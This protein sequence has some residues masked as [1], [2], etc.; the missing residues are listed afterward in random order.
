MRYVTLAR[1]GRTALNTEGRL[2]GLA[3]PPLDDEGR[4]EAA[5]LAGDLAGWNPL[6]VLCSPLH[7]ARDTAWAI[8]GRGGAELRTDKHFNDRD[9]G[10]WTGEVKAEV[11]A[12]FGS[13]DAAPGVESLDT[14][15]ERARRGLARVVSG[16]PERVVV[17]THDAVIR[18]VLAW[19][20]PAVEA[21][22]SVPTASWCRLAYDDRADAW[23]VDLVDQKPTSSWSA[24]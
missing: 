22:A 6:L 2:R 17:V 21:A 5:R 7:R 3:D 1:H 9:Y 19:I 13:V 14:V 12:R 15:L 16:R 4:E 11:V 20:D 10:A 23:R 18:A 8:A 24:S